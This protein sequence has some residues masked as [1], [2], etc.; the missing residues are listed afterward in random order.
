MRLIRVQLSCIA[1]VIRQP[2]FTLGNNAHIFLDMLT[3][4]KIRLRRRLSSIAKKHHKT[5]HR[6]TATTPNEAISSPLVTGDS[7][8]AS[9]SSC[10]RGG[11]AKA[12]PCL[13][14]LTRE[15]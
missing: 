9:F 13:K 10:R 2:F 1:T 4:E 8:V 6:S 14:T 15:K 3:I 11:S 5:L 12:K 7:H